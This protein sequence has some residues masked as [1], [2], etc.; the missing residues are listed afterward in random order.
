MENGIVILASEFI[1]D[2]KQGGVG[3]LPREIH[4][5][6]AGKN[7]ALIF[8]L[9][10]QVRNFDVEMSRDHLLNMIDRDQFFFGFDNI[11]EYFFGRMDVDGGLRQGRESSDAYE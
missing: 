2:L 6:L 5:D 10:L 1:S 4:S 7:I 9:R 8:P 3:H 11:L